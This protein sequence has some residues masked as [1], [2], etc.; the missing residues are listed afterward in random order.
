MNLIA[1]GKECVNQKDGYCM[2]K[3]IPVLKTTKEDCLY[4]HKSSPLHGQEPL[5]P[6]VPEGLRDGTQ[7]D[8][9]HGDL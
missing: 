6:R 4:F 2:L 3:G 1:C 8:Q 5:F 9:L 7:A